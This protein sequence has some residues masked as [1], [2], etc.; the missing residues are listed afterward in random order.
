MTR[1]HR[2][3][4]FAIIDPDLTTGRE[5]ICL[6]PCIVQQEKPHLNFNA[7]QNNLLITEMKTFLA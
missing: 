7:G 1:T 5:I 4:N 2:Q 6:L 3:R